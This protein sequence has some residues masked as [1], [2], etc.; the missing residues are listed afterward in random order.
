METYDLIVIGGGPAGY[1]AAAY[2]AENG[3]STVLFERAEL[4]GVCLNEG[5]VPSKTLL[6]SAKIFNYVKHSENY[7]VSVQ[8]KGELSQAAVIDRKNKVVK[9]LVTGVKSKLKN[10]GVRYV[11]ATASIVEKRDGAFIVKAEENEYFAKYVLLATGSRALIPNI[12]GVKEGIASGFVATNK[13]ILDLRE[14]PEKLVIVGGGVIGLEMADYYVIAGSKVTVIEMMD[15][16]AGATD[17]NVTAIL[18]KALEKEGVEFKL[19]A[20]VTEIKEKAVL[21]EDADGLH[22]IP[23]DKVLLSIGRVAASNGLGLEELGVNMH[24]GYVVTDAHMRTNIE[25]LYAAGDVNGKVMFAHTAYREGEVAVNTILGKP[26]EMNYNTIPSV[27]YTM[28]EV[29]CVGY[30]AD[31]A[32]EIGIDAETVALSLMYSGRYIAEN[33]DYTGVCRL[34][35]DKAKGVLIGAQIVGSYASEY[36]VAVSELIDLQVPV[37]RVKKLVFPHPTVCEVIREGVFQIK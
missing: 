28:P 11:A 17:I 23:A 37:E 19:S 9:R 16:I 5:C 27:I 1:N 3:L 20:K 32:A 14:I 22:E 33:T 35:Y 26:D 24:K 25:G 13:E 21:Y 30:T 10:A 31:A 29:A 4:G 12:S 6:N 8:D 18:K 15:R 34:V 7:G 36:I 2:A